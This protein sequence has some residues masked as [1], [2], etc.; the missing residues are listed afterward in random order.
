MV[1]IFII[2]GTVLTSLL[3]MDRYWPTGHY[4]YLL[5]LAVM[6]TILVIMDLFVIEPLFT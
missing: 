6:V 5:L 4:Y 2:D 1:T 3:C